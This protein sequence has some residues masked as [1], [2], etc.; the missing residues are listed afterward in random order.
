MQITIQD[1]SPVEKRV[2]FELPWTDVA[3]RLD[4]AYD[5]LRREVRLKGFR[6]GK[7]PRPVLERL[8]R[9]DI[10]NDVARELIELSLGQAIREKQLE[11]VAPP[12]VE[13]LELKSGQ[14]FKFSAHV[15]VRSQVEPKDYT[16]LPVSRR[17][18]KVTD[19]Q[20]AE[21]LENHRRQLT[22][23]VPVEGRTITENSD[24]VLIEVHGKVGDHK[25]KKNTFMVDLADDAGGALP[26]LAS[27]L[28]GL[29]V[30]GDKHEIKYTIADDVQQ[31]ELAGQQVSLQ[32][33][34][35][36]ARLRKVPDLDDEFAK[37]T[38]EADTLEALKQ[39]IRD[40]LVE[41]ENQKIKREMNGA[42][43]RELVKRNPFPIAPSLVD[44][45]A[46]AIVYR[47][48]YQLAM[49]GIDVESGAVDEAK[50]KKDFAAEAEEQARGSVLVRAIAA[51][52]G[53]EVSDADLQKRLAE[54][55]AARQDNVKRLRAEL[56]QNGQIESLRGQ[57]LEEKT[58]DMLL[59]QAKITD[60]DPDRR[61]VTPDEAQAAGAGSGRLVVT[62]EEAA[63]EAVEKAGTR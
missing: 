16:G 6:P 14:P 37:D 21:A 61:I 43:L 48:K 10:E 20:I 33:V 29:P 8:Y 34:I 55:A 54:L 56:E 24:V 32:V 1:L 44:R 46:D 25:V 31:R 53:I 60:E 59:H 39:K 11:P 36:E 30:G 19:E 22:E 57:L 49:M 17:P 18:P 26:G 45:H 58:L 3:P 2:D 51:K 12:R 27:R 15:E 13:K 40:R 23:F 7:A 50:M 28:R 42:L 62:P 35:K 52:E 63:A 47:A 9:Q 41:A 5:T 4:R 38:G